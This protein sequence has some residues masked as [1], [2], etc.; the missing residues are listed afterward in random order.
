MRRTALGELLRRD[1]SEGRRQIVEAIEVSDGN[2][3]R[4]AFLLGVCRF[5]L[6]RLLYQEKLWRQCNSVRL[7][8][9]QERRILAA[10]RKTT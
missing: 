10:V 1:R 2:L 6:Y 7:R 8:V 9:A 4:A 3:R 5:H